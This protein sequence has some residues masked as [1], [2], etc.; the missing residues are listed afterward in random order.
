MKGDG[1]VPKID[2]PWRA[3][4]LVSLIGA[5]MAVCVIGG[6]YLGRYVDSLLSTKP[7]FLMVGLLLGLGIGVYS[8]YRIVRGYL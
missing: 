6:V 3:V 7:W 4:T 5:D 1:Y 8:V 2:N